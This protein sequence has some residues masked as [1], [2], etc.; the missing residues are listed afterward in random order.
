[1]PF[2]NREREIRKVKAL[3]SGE[4]NLIYFVYGP[5]NNGKTALLM[6]VFKGLP[7]DYVIF[8]FNFRGIYIA[9]IED[10]LQ[11]LF[12]IKVG[13]HK[14]EIKEVLK[15]FFKEGTRR[16]K[17]TK[18]IPIPESIFDRIFSEKKFENI[19]RYLETVFEEIR[20]NGKVPIFVLDELQSIKEV[21]NTAG[22]PLIHE[23]FNFMVRLTK[24]THLCHCLCATSD[25][26]FIEDIYSNARL[27]GRAEYLLIDDL[28]KECAFRM[29]SEFGFEDK[30]LVWDYIGG[31]IGDMIRLYEKKKGG[32][33]EREGVE[34][35]LMD[36]KGRLRWF[37]RLIKEGEKGNI[38]LEEVKDVLKLF[39]EKE[40]IN[41]E[42]IEGKVLRLLIEENVLF[43]N[44]VKGVV[45]PQSRI[46][47]KAIKELV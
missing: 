13:E 29:Y 38:S 28:D 40:V 3:L 39:K 15:E 23:L 35:I 30:E 36:T 32:L 16:L 17:K 34:E 26:L 12:E 46:I 9:S 5:I 24:E 4:P 47:E 42:E 8:Y 31:K 18:G 10:L 14:T 6:E 44:P 37:F 41:E 27:E 20:E 7:K 2:Y 21:I 19:F 22:R 11:V 1:M 43:Y 25:C 33:N 45:R